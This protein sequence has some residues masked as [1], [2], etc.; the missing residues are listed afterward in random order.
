MI[1]GKVKGIRL[2]LGLS[3]SQLAGKDM[4][5]AFV[6]QVENGRCQPS[7]RTLRLLAARLGKPISYFLEDEDPESFGLNMIWESAQ[8]DVE[9]EQWASAL[10]KVEEALQLVRRIE[11]PLREADIQFL[12]GRCL[13]WVGRRDEALDQFEDALERYRLMGLRL[14]VMETWLEIGNCY[15]LLE[16]YAAAQRLYQKV[17]RHSR[18]MKTARELHSLAL[19][20]LGTAH[21]R[22]GAHTEA[23]GAYREALNRTDRT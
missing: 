7:F 6:S 19:C 23:V 11:D 13:F 17:I 12:Y 5:R 4:T 16:Q 1:G 14:K 15:L 21:T 22:V 10:P 20:Y 9:M 8:Q 3:Q 2:K 18:G